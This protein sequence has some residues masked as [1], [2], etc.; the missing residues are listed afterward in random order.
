MKRR[1]K[2]LLDRRW[3]D[4][5]READSFATLAASL[6]DLLAEDGEVIH[7]AV[8]GSAVSVAAALADRGKSGLGQIS[9]RGGL[10]AFTYTRTVGKKRKRRYKGDFAVCRWEDSSAYVIVCCGTP[11]FIR[12][13]LEP[14]ITSLYPQ[15]VVPF[16][17]QDELHSVVRAVQ[18][19]AQPDALRIHEYSAKRRITSARRRFESVRDWTDVE[20][21]A[22]FREAKERNVWFSSVRFQLLRRPGEEPSRWSGSRYRLSKYGAVSCD[23]GFE[24][25][26]ASVLPMLTAITSERVRFFSNRERSSQSTDGLHPLE[27]RYDKP[28]LTSSPDLKRLLDVLRRFPHGTCTVLHANPYLHVTLVD[29][30]DLSAADVWVLSERGILLVPQL[31]ASYGALKRLVNHIFE[32][33][34]EGQI[35][36]A[37]TH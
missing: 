13:A 28:L 37:K 9:Q 31:R 2:P 29:D 23:S 11:T 20:P 12:N 16:L 21:D 25:V 35:G 3:P 22:A 7:I 8:L 14:L 15:V 24:L 1:R 26:I 27:I 10:S 30:I 5:I 18:R 32:N 34:G 6:S 33:F 36:E 19:R 4:L 17:S